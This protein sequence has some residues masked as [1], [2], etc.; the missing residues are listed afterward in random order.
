MDTEYNKLVMDKIISLI[1][2]ANLNVVILVPGLPETNSRIESLKT[3]IGSLDDAVI[4][5]NNSRS[6]GAVTNDIINEEDFINED[7][8][9]SAAEKIVIS[10]SN[11]ALVIDKMISMQNKKS[12]IMIASGLSFE[13]G[14]KNIAKRLAN[15]KCE[16]SYDIGEDVIE[17]Y[18]KYIRKE[19]DVVIVLSDK[20]SFDTYELYHKTVYRDTVISFKNLIWY[21]PSL[22]KYAIN[23]KMT[24]KD[25]FEILYTFPNDN[26]RN[27]YIELI[28]DELLPWDFNSEN[29][30]SGI[31]RL[32]SLNK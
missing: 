29:T 30:L 6:L 1:R 31:G 19:Y 9:E 5:S 32:N 12:K 3:V 13:V 24:F 7:E 11:N 4:V 16:Y 20:W 18:Y 23:R 14:L 2:R 27:E 10:C 28:H 21:D 17:K 15:L 25:L 22:G 8:C 26:I